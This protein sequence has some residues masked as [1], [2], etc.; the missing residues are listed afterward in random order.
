MPD[1]DIDKIMEEYGDSDF[2]FSAVSEEDYNRV[3][4][5]TADTV[6][7]YK[8]RLEQV[9]KLILPFFT[10]L[11]AT[12]EKEYIYWPN[13]RKTIEAQVQKILALTRG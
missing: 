1:F 8:E 9:E 11:L 3:I 6:E 4:N 5:E 7:E 2:G 12:S 10:K 13:R